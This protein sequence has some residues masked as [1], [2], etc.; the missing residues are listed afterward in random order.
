[1]TSALLSS[2]AWLLCVLCINGQF[3][4]TPGIGGASLVGGAV[5]LTGVQPGHY[6][7]E[8]Q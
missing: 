6:R 7:I 8:S 3:K 2:K 1:M 5:Q 4:A